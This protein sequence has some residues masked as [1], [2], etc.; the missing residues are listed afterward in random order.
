MVVI[1]ASK[2]DQLRCPSLA[3]L[4]GPNP[5]GPVG[6]LLRQ[7]T[8]IDHRAAQ[9]TPARGPQNGNGSYEAQGA[10]EETSHHGLRE[11]SQCPNEQSSQN[12][13][14]EILPPQI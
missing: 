1:P 3:I 13:A 5:A 8:P 9:N 2:R 12:I 11:G 4:A 14:R 10:S 6:V 7:S